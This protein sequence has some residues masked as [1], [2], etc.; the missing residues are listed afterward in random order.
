MSFRIQDSNYSP[1][2]SWLKANLILL[3]LFDT[4]L[5]FSVPPGFPNITVPQWVD[6]DEETSITCTVEAKPGVDL[7][8]DVNGTTYDP[9]PSLGD[10]PGGTVITTVS[11]A[12]QFGKQPARQLVTCVATVLNEPLDVL[13]YTRKE[14]DVFCKL[15]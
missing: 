5:P 10:G 15:T 7:Y 12:H 14:V 6:A 4:L 13:N 3:L 1:L 9:T 2:N 8:V 11:L